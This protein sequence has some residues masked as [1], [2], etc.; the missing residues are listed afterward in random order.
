MDHAH[1]D[2][3]SATATT[4]TAPDLPSSTRDRVA[5]K[6]PVCGMDVVG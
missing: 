5:S 2:H 3:A 6:D 4:I 1:H